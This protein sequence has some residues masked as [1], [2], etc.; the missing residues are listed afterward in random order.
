MPLGFYQGVKTWLCQSLFSLFPYGELKSKG[1]PLERGLLQLAKPRDKI[2]R[3]LL[4]IQRSTVPKGKSLAY[5]QASLLN[6]GLGA[7]APSKNKALA[8]LW[9]VL[10]L[11]LFN[12][13]AV[14]QR[15]PSKPRSKGLPSERLKTNPSLWEGGEC[16]IPR[17]GKGKDEAK[18]K[19]VKVQLFQH[20]P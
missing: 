17:R 14:E 4:F 6:K 7:P 13:E 5:S 1:L 18:Q 15:A 19:S 10:L 2:S 3:P 8:F 12:S 20:L 9:S 16:L 11:G